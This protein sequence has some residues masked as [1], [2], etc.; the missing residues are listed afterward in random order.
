M[1]DT[2]R[3]GQEPARPPWRRALPVAAAGLILALTAAAGFA[4]GRATAPES[5]VL[6][7]DC[8][9]VKATGDRLAQETVPDG[10]TQAAKDARMAPMLNLMLQNPACFS[11]ETRANA[12]TLKDQAASRAASGAESDAAARAAQCLDPD[13]WTSIC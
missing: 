8:A 1:S 10:E 6:S 5:D 2:G 9:E 13:R 12:Q 7:E 11:A 4:A 3:P